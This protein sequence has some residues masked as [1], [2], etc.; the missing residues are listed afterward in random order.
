MDKFK[1]GGVKNL[2]HTCSCCSISKEVE[3]LSDRSTLMKCGFLFGCE[4]WHLIFE[5]N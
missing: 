1:F 2:G 3:I 5:K 4:W